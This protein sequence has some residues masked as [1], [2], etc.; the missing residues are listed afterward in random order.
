MM[1][2][3]VLGSGRNGVLRLVNTAA[4]TCAPLAGGLVVRRSEAA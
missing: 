3:A 2:I 1:R 4:P